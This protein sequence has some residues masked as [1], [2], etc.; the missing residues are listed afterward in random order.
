M[1]LKLLQKVKTLTG[2][3]EGQPLHKTNNGLYE[4]LLQ[5]NHH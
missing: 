4:Q 1:E 3:Q 2:A 5:I